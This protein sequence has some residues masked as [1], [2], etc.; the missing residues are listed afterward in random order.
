MSQ[1][2][3][4]SDALA[5]FQQALDDGHIHLRRG[6]LDP[7]IFLY[8]DKINGHARFTY[9]W[10]DKRPVTAF[11]NMTPV[12]PIDGIPCLQ[13]GCAIQPSTNSPDRRH[14]HGQPEPSQLTPRIRDT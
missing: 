9:V 2:T 8:A 7:D 6:E 3:D 11:V 14:L 10:L 13:I 5:S 4:P 12:Q 1:M